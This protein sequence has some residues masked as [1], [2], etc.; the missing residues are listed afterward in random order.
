MVHSIAEILRRKTKL[1]KNYSDDVD[2][3]I[4]KL[5][6]YWHSCYRAYTYA[7]TH[8][9]LVQFQQVSFKGAQ[10]WRKHLH[11]S[12]RDVMHLWLQVNVSA[13]IAEQIQI[14]G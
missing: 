3:M 1:L 8:S 14:V 13:Q 12:V 7:F 11:V 5:R 6:S 2:R 4:A 9:D 10:Q